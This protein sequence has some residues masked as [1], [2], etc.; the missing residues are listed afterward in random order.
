[1]FCRIVT[2]HSLNYFLSVLFSMNF[3]FLGG[4]G[5]GPPGGPRRRFGGFNTGQAGPAG[6]PPM[7]GG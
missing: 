4:R 7:A 6:G 3:F 5:G 1:M 2:N